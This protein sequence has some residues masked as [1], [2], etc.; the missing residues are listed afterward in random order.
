MK[1][2]KLS[3][4]LL[5]AVLTASVSAGCLDKKTS[6]SVDEPVIS[7]NATNGEAL[8]PRTDNTSHGDIGQ[9]KIDGEFD[10]EI[11]ENDMGFTLHS[12]IVPEIR[13]GGQKFVYLDIT[14]RNY[15]DAAYNIST[16]NNFYIILPDGQEVYSDVR[17]QLYAQSNFS[18]DKYF[19]DPFDIPS[20]GQF[21]GTIGGFTI[22]ED[23]N[24]FTLGFYPT[25]SDSHAKETV[26]L[27]KITADDLKAPDS[28]LLK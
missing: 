24:E 5:T 11:K 20:N 13:E 27:Y 8:T 16:L 18:A 28:A 25:G 17:T 10:K 22:G 26:V 1:T 9:N 4:L 23:V 6:V 7:T 15:T 3:A 19:L 21:S 14:L 2:S 12:V